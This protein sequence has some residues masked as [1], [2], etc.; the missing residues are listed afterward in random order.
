MKTLALTAAALVALSA[1]VFAQSQLEQ[2]L[3]VQP[4]AYS[5][6]QLIELKAAAE[7]DGVN[8]WVRFDTAAPATNVSMS[9]SGYADARVARIV[10]A[11][12]KASDN[13]YT[14]VVGYR[15]NG[16]A[17]EKI[18]NARVAEIAAELAANAD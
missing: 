15:D 4:G 17:N 1:P 12:A 9:T 5:L 16:P 7:K 3:S 2:D 8:G 14:S 18:A 13:G 6:N 11:H 10:A